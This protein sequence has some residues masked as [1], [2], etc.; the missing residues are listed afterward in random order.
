MIVIKS[1][2]I[3]IS[4]PVIDNGNRTPIVDQITVIAYY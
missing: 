3:D 2:T 4:V 1:S